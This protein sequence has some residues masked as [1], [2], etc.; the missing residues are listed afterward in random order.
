MSRQNRE[1]NDTNSWLRALYTLLSVALLLLVTTPNTSAQTKRKS[2]ESSKNTTQTTTETT[3]IKAGMTAP[4]GGVYG[5][6]SRRTLISNGSLVPHI[7]TDSTTVDGERRELTQAEA[8]S[9][10]K[11]QQ[12]SLALLSVAGA[13]AEEQPTEERKR[14]F[15]DSMSLSKVVWAGA[16]LP[17]FGQI[18]NKQYW[19]LPVIYG[20]M[21]GT[22]LLFIHENKKYQPLKDRYTE[23][24]LNDARRTVEINEVQTEMIKSNT[25]RQVYLGGLVASYI[26][27][28]GDAAMNYATNDVSD[29]KRATTLATICPGAGQIYNKSYWKVPFVVGGFAMMTYVIDWNNRGYKRFKKAYSLRAAYDTDPDA[30]PDGSTDEFGGRYSADY[31]KSLRDSYRR[32]R[33]MSFIF[34]AGLYVLQIVDAHVDAHFKDF[35][36]SDD[37]SLNIEPTFGYSYSP[38]QRSECATYGFNVGLKF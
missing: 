37:L 29:I 33:D 26:Y 2:S 19:K 6:S 17:G 24:T 14:Y 16:V 27:S 32:N 11:E 4:D 20:A 5:R 34:V 22:T 18:Y 38:S 31:L 25:R 15:S 30:Y 1:R 23:L 9:L 8:D 7:P 10:A 21:A 12:K 28:L 13:T 36:I 35:D 3:E